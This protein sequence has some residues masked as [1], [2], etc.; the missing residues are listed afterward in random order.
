M[1]DGDGA[2]SHSPTPKI[3][4]CRSL[5]ARTGDGSGGDED[6]AADRHWSSNGAAKPKLGAASLPV[7]WS[8]RPR[9][10]VSRHA[11]WRESHRHVCLIFSDHRR[12]A[13]SISARRL[14]LRRAVCRRH[15][16]QRQTSREDCT[17]RS[18]GRRRMAVPPLAPGCPGGGYDA[19]N[20]H[21]SMMQPSR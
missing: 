2:S 9:L 15:G 8:H 10:R 20:G 5:S 7:Q 14:W 3:C 18:S 13:S 17:S 4:H 21:W 12:I 19:L 11:N 16:R 1:L 6:G